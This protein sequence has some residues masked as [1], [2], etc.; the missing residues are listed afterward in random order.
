LTV[1]CHPVLLKS[2]LLRWEHKSELATYPSMGIVSGLPS[3]A[4]F[5]VESGH[6]AIEQ[7]LRYE[8]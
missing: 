6:Y 3:R 5:H 1:N 4:E 7:L 2:S 8:I